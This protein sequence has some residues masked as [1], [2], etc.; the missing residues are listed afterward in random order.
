MFI[1][2]RD[3]SSDKITLHGVHHVLLFVG[4]CLLLLPKAR[5]EPLRCSHSATPTPTP[6]ILHV[7]TKCIAN[8][9]AMLVRSG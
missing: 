8:E 9:A 7:Q 3:K 2:R 6:T 4:I 5:D 1:V